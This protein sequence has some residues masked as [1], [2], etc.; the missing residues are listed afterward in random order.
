MEIRCK[1][2]QEFF[3]PGDDNLE[4]IMEGYITADSV[5]MC[6]DCWNLQQLSEYDY[7]DSLGDSD[8]VM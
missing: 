8:S 2:C 6:D 3:N 4:L 5:N 1:C 7:S